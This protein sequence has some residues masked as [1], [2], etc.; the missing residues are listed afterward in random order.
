MGCEPIKMVEFIGLEKWVSGH[1]FWIHFPGKMALRGF[2]PWRRLNNMML[3]VSILNIPRRVTIM[4]I[5]TLNITQ[6]AL[7]AP[8][9]LI[10]LTKPLLLRLRSA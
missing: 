9:S 4:V 10:N 2:A 5:H 3:L 1:R 7:K 8:K 6:N